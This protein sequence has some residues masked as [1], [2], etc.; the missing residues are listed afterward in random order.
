M[1]KVTVHQFNMGDVEDPDLWAAQHLVEF[2]TSE[3]GKWVMEN[4]IDPTWN[5]SIDHSHYGW[6]YTITTSMTEQQLIYYK[7]KYE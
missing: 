2:E 1:R 3:K 4:T 6:H 7:L 5:R